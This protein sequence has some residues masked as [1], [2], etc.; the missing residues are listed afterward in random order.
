MKNKIFRIL[1]L[2]VS[3]F[4]ALLCLGMVFGGMQALSF[5]VI[6]FIAAMIIYLIMCIIQLNYLQR[7]KHD[8][9]KN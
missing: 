6:P 3:I 2:I 8:G 9:N 1:I 5:A 4:P 7:N